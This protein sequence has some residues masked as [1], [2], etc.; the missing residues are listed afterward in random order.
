[1]S[2]NSKS[3]YEEFLIAE[4]SNIAQAH[5]N[6]ESTIS[7]FF[8]HYMLIVSIP[9]TLFAI[10]LRF[11]GQHQLDSVL[12]PTILAA[13]PWIM[14]LIGF[15]GLCVMVYIMNLRFD[16]ILYARAVNGIRSYFSKRSNIA[17]DEELRQR[18]LPRTIQF[19]PYFEGTYFLFPVL[20]F[21]GFNSFYFTFAYC[22][23]SDQ[24]W[25]RVWFFMFVCAFHLLA[26]MW[27]A[28]YRESGYLRSKIIGIDID[29][30]LNHHRQHFCKML[31]EICDKDLDPNDI[32]DIPVHNV[33]GINVTESDEH[34]IFNHPNYWTDMP[35]DDEATNFLRRLKNDLG[36]KIVIFTHRGWPEPE[37]FPKDKIAQYESY[38][39]EVDSRWRRGNVA[40][41]K[42]TRN[43]LQKVQISYDRLVVEMG[44]IYTMDPQSAKRNRFVISQSKNIRLFVED[45]LWNAKKLSFVCEV[46]FLID[47]PY[48][49]LRTEDGELASNIIRVT[50]WK[51]IFDFIRKK[52]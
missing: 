27:L 15:I 13:L 50:S 25:L 26:Y 9:I 40:I 43:W 7:N 21:A 24:I 33:P 10:F 32:I 6:T 39:D 41:E 2:D 47:H 28:N 45:D 20:A 42:I 35:V 18:A 30:V 29:G 46:V 51:E 23:Y 48:N 8:K 44:N 36:Y 1:M 3:P 5:F 4:Y 17:F 38:W 31:L 22:C 49:Q 14:V 52:L 11:P 19:P 37:T 16:A 12:I 34:D